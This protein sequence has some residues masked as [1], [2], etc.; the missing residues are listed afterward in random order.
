MSGAAKAGLSK[1]LPKLF[2]HWRRFELGYLRARAAQGWSGVEIA[3]RLRRT[4]GAV[5]EQAKKHGIVL[6]PRPARPPSAPRASKRRRWSAAEDAAL[7]AARAAGEE[8]RAVAE[9]L[10]RSLMAVQRRMWVLGLTEDTCPWSA[11]EDR[12]LAEAWARGETGRAIAAVL[13]RSHWGVLARARLLGLTAPGR[14]RRRP[15]RAFEIAY[16]RARAAQG[17]T[18]AEIARRLRRDATSIRDAAGTHAIA[19]PQRKPGCKPRS[20]GAQP[21]HGGPEKRR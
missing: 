10:G 5:Y 17:M 19:L 16:I 11:A 13:G 6:Q 7:R 14:R 8:Y 18:T 12:I 21:E 4:R 20:P 3:R 15:F 2:R 1:P 9:R